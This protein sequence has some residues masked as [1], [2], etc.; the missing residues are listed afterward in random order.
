VKKFTRIEPTTVEEFGSKYKRQAVIKR[1]QTEDGMRHEFTMINKEGA[2]AA[3]VIA[4]TPDNQV[5]SMYEFRPNS[6]SWVYEIPGGS[7]YESEDPET[8]AIRE[9]REET[10]YVPGNIQYLGESYDDACANMVRHYYFATDCRLDKDGA[11]L[12][13]EE[14]EQGA[15]MRLITIN[16]LIDSAIGGTM[17][18]PRAVLQAYEK[19]KELEGGK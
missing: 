6:E 5:I 7:L 15:E 10:G 2:R 1:F 16:E 17:T 19:L 12:D 8:G 9:L 18:D 11:V 14:H 3:A 13:R 4:L